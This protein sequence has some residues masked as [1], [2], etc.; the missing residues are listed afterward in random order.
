MA[1][2]VYQMA[3]LARETLAS[4]RIVLLD[5]APLRLGGNLG[6]PS[7]RSASPAL[8]PFELRLCEGQRVVAGAMV[9]QAEHTFQHAVEVRHT[10]HRSGARHA[11]ARRS[12]ALLAN[13]GVPLLRR[14]VCLVEPLRPALQR[15]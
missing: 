1:S 2:A 5:Y 11:G 9:V 14:A 15:Q 10:V 7:S 12:P 6:R 4:R 3:I 8:P 13:R